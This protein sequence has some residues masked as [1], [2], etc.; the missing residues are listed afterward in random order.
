MSQLPQNFRRR[1]E[2]D[3]GGEDNRALD[4]EPDERHSLESWE[5]KESGVPR[6]VVKKYSPMIEVS[7]MDQEIRSRWYHLTIREREVAALVCTG[8]RNYEIAERL[9]VTYGT[10]RT[11]LQRIFSKLGVRSR[12]EIRVMLK[13]WNAEKWWIAHH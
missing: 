8:E 1:F 2:K 12:K 6:V 3:T 9:G 11:Y 10:V 7:P 5:Q 4:Y 13:S